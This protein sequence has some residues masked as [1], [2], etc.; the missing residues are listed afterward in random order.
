MKLTVVTPS[1]NQAAFL[2]Q[3]LRSV[4]SQREH[5]HEYF[6]LDGGSTDA[7]AQIIRRYEQHIDWWVS[8]KDRGQCDAIHRG[9]QRATGD[10]LYWINS[11]DVLLPGTLARVHAAFDADPSLDVVTGWG[12]AIDGEGRIVGMKRPVHDSLRWASLGYLRAHQ[13]CTFFRR[14]LYEKVGGLDLDLHCVLDTELWYRMFRAGSRWGG[15][16]GYVAAYRLHGEAKGTVLAD[17]YRAERAILKEKYPDLTG[18]KLRHTLGRIAY[19][20]AQ[21]ASGRAVASRVDMRRHRGRPLIEVF[22]DWQVKAAS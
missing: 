10:V 22:G 4:I 21:L 6:V 3:T 13:P 1:Y 19:Y 9:F 20:T 11:D 17:R 7:S 14:E 16:S 5:V 8:E 2:E 18:H 12:V 15:I